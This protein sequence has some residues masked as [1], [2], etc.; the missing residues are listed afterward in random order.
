MEVR[1]ALVG[2][3][4][5]RVLPLGAKASVGDLVQAA[6]RSL[7]VSPEWLRVCLNGQ[8]LKAAGSGKSRFLVP[9]EGGGAAEA[10]R[11]ASLVGRG[12]YMVSLMFP[13]WARISLHTS[14]PPPKKRQRVRNQPAVQKN[15]NL[16]LHETIDAPSGRGSNGEEAE[17]FHVFVEGIPSFPSPFL[18]LEL[19]TKNPTVELLRKKLAEITGSE[20]TL[21][22]KETPLGAARQY[23]HSAGGVEPGSVITATPHGQGGVASEQAEPSPANVAAVAPPAPANVAAVVTSDA[24]GESPGSEEDAEAGREDPAKKPRLLP[25][26]TARKG[27]VVWAGSSRRRLL[28]TGERPAREAG[29]AALEASLADA[30]SDAAEAGVRQGGSAAGGF[31]GQ[32]N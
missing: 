15:S 30:L 5:V 26:G 28:S 3:P 10:A 6:G 23:L 2:A 32:Q 12:V 18:R 1:W 25:L 21:A 24:P 31:F 13:M 11:G 8:D 16:L 22:H 17:S 20:F 27:G 9:S 19:A 14:A 7:S 29:A 4:A